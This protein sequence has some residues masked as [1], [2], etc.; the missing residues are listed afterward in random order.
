[1]RLIERLFSG[2]V[3]DGEQTYQVLLDLPLTVYLSDKGI[4][5]LNFQVNVLCNANKK[6]TCCCLFLIL[7][8]NSSNI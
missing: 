3:P 6:K 1:M 2:K 7:R 5:S 8:K 4:G